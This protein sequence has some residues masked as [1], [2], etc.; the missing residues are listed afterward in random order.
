MEEK[1]AKPDYPNAR[2]GRSP[3]L[4]LWL[5]PRQ[6][7]RWFL[8]SDDPWKNALLLAVL[9]GAL[10]GLSTASGDNWGDDL[11][12]PGLI[13]RALVVGSIGGLLGYYLGA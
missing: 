2:D 6:V 8:N 4:E 13:I 11:S 12:M 3:W 1:S 10:G 5:H 7:T 9:S